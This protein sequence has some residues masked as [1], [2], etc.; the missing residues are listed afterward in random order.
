ML[1]GG[2]KQRLV[3]ARMFLKNPK[4]LI[5]DEA[6]SA[7]D[8]I[9]EQE[10]QQKLDDLMRGRTTISIA[11]R[12]S[13]IK[14]CDEIVVLGKNGQGIVQRGDFET[15]KKVKGHFQN[16]YKAGLME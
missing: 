13:T 15:L 10:I 8:N 5:L 11:H 6:T 16:L 12:L 2:Q 3:I 1:S 4:V 14:N 9:V 7:L